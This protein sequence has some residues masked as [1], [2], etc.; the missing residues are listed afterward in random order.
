MELNSVRRLVY[1]H[2]PDYYEIDELKEKNILYDCYNYYIF[3]NEF[4]INFEELEYIY[5]GDII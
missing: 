3:N 4:I 5:G 2:E 1:E